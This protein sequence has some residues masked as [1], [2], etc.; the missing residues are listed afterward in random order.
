MPMLAIAPFLAFSALCT[1]AIA[2]VVGVVTFRRHREPREHDV[3]REI[4]DLTL[5]VRSPWQ[6]RLEQVKRWME[7]N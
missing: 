4:A 5:K 1:A 7:R 2:A 6:Y 3:E